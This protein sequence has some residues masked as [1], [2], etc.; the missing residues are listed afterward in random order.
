MILLCFL[1]E[2]ISSNIPEILFSYPKYD[3]D[4]D[5]DDDVN[6]VFELFP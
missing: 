4:V 3:D 1:W 6:I 5:N 2:M